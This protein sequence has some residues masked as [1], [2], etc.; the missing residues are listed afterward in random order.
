MNVTLR[1][2]RKEQWYLEHQAHLNHYK[3]VFKTDDYP[4]GTRRQVAKL[5][6]ECFAGCDMKKSVLA[7]AQFHRCDFAGADLSYADLD[8]TYFMG[9]DLRGAKFTRIP[10]SAVLTGSLINLEDLPLT[11]V[12]IPLVED[13]HRKVY[14][15]ITGDSCR[16]DMRQWHTCETIHCRAGWVSTIAFGKER[17]IAENMHPVSILALAV[18]LKAYPGMPVPDWYTSDGDAM[19]DIRALAFGG[20]NA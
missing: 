14:D 17:W 12:E 2:P 15:A 9:C 16:L 10:L 4:P 1:T 5:E 3:V 20:S 13:L 11:N 7:M 6:E 8:G 18:Y 19:L